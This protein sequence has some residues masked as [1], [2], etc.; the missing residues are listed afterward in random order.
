M[1]AFKV[2]TC[3]G[4]VMARNVY[5]YDTGESYYE[6]Y[7]PTTDDECGYGKYIGEFHSQYDYNDDYER[8][9]FIEDLE[10]MLDDEDYI[11]TPTKSTPQQQQHNI[12]TKLNNLVHKRFS[13]KSLEEELSKI[14]GGEEIHIELGQEDVDYLTDWD[15][16]FTSGQDVIGGD[17]DIYVLYHKNCRPH[18]FDGST[19]M[20]TEIACDFFEH[21]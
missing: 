8:D 16:M 6:V 10:V 21:F 11:G 20:V 18:N 7:E 5:D 1:G 3:Y 14:F 17:F 2:E 19:F 15:Y 12:Y 13:K 9:L 4:D